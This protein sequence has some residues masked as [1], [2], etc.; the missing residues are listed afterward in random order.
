MVFNVIKRLYFGI[1]TKNYATLVSSIG[2]LSFYSDSSLDLRLV[3]T[4]SIE[5]RHQSKI[6]YRSTK[7][8]IHSFHN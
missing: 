6:V 7:L 1:E 3:S 2:D 4:F 5:Y 8:W